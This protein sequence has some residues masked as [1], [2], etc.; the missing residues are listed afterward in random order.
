MK[1]GVLRNFSKFT[2]K[3]L[4]H[5]LFFNKFATLLK[6]L[7]KNMQLYYKSDLAQVFSCEFY[8]ISKNVFFTEHLWAT[9]SENALLK[10]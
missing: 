4:C 2:G 6:T 1:K 5:G 7:L 8:E 10:H 9:A 3:N